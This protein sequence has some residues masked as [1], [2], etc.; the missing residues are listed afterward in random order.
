MHLTL[1]LI[2]YYKI[3]K[4]SL[5]AILYTFLRCPNLFP[6]RSVLYNVFQRY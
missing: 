3:N 2:Y 1:D 5:L 4:T 6:A